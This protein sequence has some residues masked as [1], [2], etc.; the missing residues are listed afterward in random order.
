MTFRANARK[1]DRGSAKPDG[2]AWSRVN[3]NCERQ[4]L[5]NIVVL[6]TV[7]LRT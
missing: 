7:R 4:F 5:P 2:V 1:D 3:M 6:S